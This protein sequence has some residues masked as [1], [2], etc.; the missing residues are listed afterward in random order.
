MILRSILLI[1]FSFNVWLISPEVLW[2]VAST[3]GDATDGVSGSLSEK[4][5]EKARG[6]RESEGS[7][8]LS[9]K[10]EKTQESLGQIYVYDSPHHLRFYIQLKNLEP[11]RS[12]RLAFLQHRLCS[13][14]INE[15]DQDQTEEVS[16][17]DA[18]LKGRP[19]LAR[20]GP[21]ESD[22]Q[23]RIIQTIHDPL[24]SFGDQE[25]RFNILGT[26]LSL[27]Y[28]DEKNQGWKKLACEE[29]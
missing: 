5:T 6:A 28:K 17:D 1:A 22:R 27:F 19:A 13:D 8:S 4:G 7:L 12:Y 29:V 11:G 24:L 10:H 20:M 9:F 23:G 16:F 25:S 2:A 18:D 15:L 14:D 3:A 21:F 26:S